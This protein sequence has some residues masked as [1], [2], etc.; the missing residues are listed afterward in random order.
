MKIFGVAVMKNE[1]DIV[2][3][4]LEHSSKWCDRI[5]VYDNGSTDGTWPI[6]QEMASAVIVAWKSEDVPFHNSLRARVFNAFRNEA[7]PG[8]WWCYRLD[9]DEFYI[10]N[11]REFLAS[12]PER[13]HTVYRKCIN[14]RISLEDAEQYQF[15][16][17]FAQ[18]RQYLRYFLPK[19]GV[20]RRFIRHREGLVW[21]EEKGLNYTGVTCPDMILA[22]HFRWRSPQQIQ[23][24]LDSKREYLLRKAE[25]KNRVD[26]KQRVDELYAAENWRDLCPPRSKMILDTGPESWEKLRWPDKKIDRVTESGFSYLFKRLLHTLK[27]LR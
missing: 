6:V 19:G 12:V 16:G 24:R 26:R 20:E 23:K 3:P 14:Y 18:D 22:Q 15:T 11:P 4:F 13:Y 8:D 21:T 27:I 17:D 10:D 1:S 25:R 5:F 7:Q 9:A 2:R